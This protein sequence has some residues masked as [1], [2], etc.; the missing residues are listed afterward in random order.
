MINVWDFDFNQVPGPDNPDYEDRDVVQRAYDHNM[1]LMS[2][3]ERRGFAGVFFSEHHFLNALSPC[4]NLLIAAL[5]QKTT[6]LR[7]GVMGNVLALHQ[8]WRLAEE[9]GM[10]D[11]LT[12]GR[13]EIGVAV[14]IP[15]EFLFVNIPTPDIRPMFNEI[16]D[17]LD[18]A[19]EGR[20]VTV[21]GKY[22]NLDDV[23]SMPR[24]RN[25]SRRRRWQTVYSE[26][27]CREAAHRGYK[28]CTGY[29]SCENAAKAFE[30]YR[31]EAL[32]GGLSV[33]ADDIGLRRQVVIW[34]TDSEAQALSAD[35]QAGG[36]RRMAHTFSAVRE[37]LER[38]GV[39][40]S[41]TVKKAG[42]IDAD[43]VPR[44]TAP[45][46]VKVTKDL[47]IQA[48]PEEF[49][50]GSPSSVA[51]QVIEQ[52]RKTGAGHLLAYH[53]MTMTESQLAHHYDL[54]EQV[55]PILEKADVSTKRAA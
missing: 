55:V 23:P 29:Q 18:K 36:Q 35:V 7:I 38:A 10:L 1:K 51:E 40:P 30:A 42:V 19:A 44:P 43:A 49:I 41:E 15:P 31:E 8:P 6:K 39:G 13:L 25:E 33:T 22:F 14:G 11:Y 37:R 45:T 3:L 27:S 32:K 4:P 34:D 9:L 50:A 48:A 53:G 54:W 52:C 5:A 21:K 47:A 12:H 24:P 17:F 16:L 2:S 26:S 28:I 20:Y 46:G